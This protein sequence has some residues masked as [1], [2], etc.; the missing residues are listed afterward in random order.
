[1]IYYRRTWSQ[2]VFNIALEY[3]AI[4][5]RKPECFVL[6]NKSCPIW[7]KPRKDGWV[8]GTPIIINDGKGGSGIFGHGKTAS[9]KY[10]VRRFIRN[11]NFEG[12]LITN[13]N[14]FHFT[15]S[16]IQNR[17]PWSRCFWCGGDADHIWISNGHHTES[18]ISWTCIIGTSNFVYLICLSHYYAV[19]LHYNGIGIDS[20]L[21]S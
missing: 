1:M 16:W 2:T 15:S 5:F 9:S 6:T 20:I 10:S 4:R 14:C 19:S 13:S 11:L 7:S 8:N 3:Y 21:K 17:D 18:Y 12:E